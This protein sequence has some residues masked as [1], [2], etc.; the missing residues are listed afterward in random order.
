MVL[1]SL[2][3]LQQKKLKRF[4]AYSSIGHVGY[5][6][7]GFATG[8]IEGVQALL[9]YSILYVILVLSAWTLF[10]RPRSR[11]EDVRYSSRIYPPCLAST[12]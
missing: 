10:Y 1:A 6:L 8:T 4:L 5:M 3:A 2:V 12:H 11:K 7:V 9:L